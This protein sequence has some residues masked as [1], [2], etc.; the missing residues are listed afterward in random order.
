MSEVRPFTVQFSDPDLADLR[1]RLA[2]TR[3]PDPE[4]VDDWSQG[5]PLAYT[6]ELCRYWQAEYDFAA[7]LHRLNAHPQFLT[8]IDGV[9]VHFIHARS[10]EP[11][12]FPIVITHG[13]PGSV[14]EFLH[15]IDPLTNPGGPRGR[16]G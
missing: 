16:P 15:V 1:E 6:Q 13:W 11:G 4:P 12:A 2:R 10:P 7:A 9:D 3:W 14:A 8:E 5:I